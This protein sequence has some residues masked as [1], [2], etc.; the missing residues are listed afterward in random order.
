MESAPG[1]GSTFT[2]R[3]PLPIVSGVQPQ[4]ESDSRA[5]AGA[6]GGL[7]PGDGCQALLVEDNEVN[8]RIARQMLERLGCS[9]ELARDGRAALELLSCRRYDIVFMD[10]EMPVMD[11]YACAAELRRRER[12]ASRTPVVAL[13]AHAMEGAR[14]RCLAA[15]MDDYLTKPL[16][17]RRLRTTLEKWFRPREHNRVEPVATPGA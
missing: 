9:V 8:Q 1:K 5:A 2:C 17:V 15:G 10:C 3:I 4:I 13:T 6:D 16:A 7:L 14:E 12:S 11:G